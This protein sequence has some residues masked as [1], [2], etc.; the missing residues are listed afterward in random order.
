MKE[1]INNINGN[2]FYIEKLD[3]QGDNKKF[4]ITFHSGNGYN[5]G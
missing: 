4:Y 5:G 1:L 3:F 2:I